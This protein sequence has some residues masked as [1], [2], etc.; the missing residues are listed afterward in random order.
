[1]G[2]PSQVSVPSPAAVHSS[3]SAVGL[4]AL[5]QLQA[6][7]ER[8]VEVGAGRPG[9]GDRHHGGPPQ[10]ISGDAVRHDTTFTHD[11]AGQL[12]PGFRPR[13]ASCY[14]RNRQVHR[15]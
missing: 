7:A 13:S 10:A 14:S 1:M 15:R 8:G 6:A 11:D 3:S 2:A 9:L 5:A 4:V 12:A